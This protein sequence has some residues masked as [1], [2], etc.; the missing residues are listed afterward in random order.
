M[1]HFFGVDNLGSSM[2]KDRKLYY[3]LHELKSDIVALYILKN[4]CVELFGKD[5]RRV[6]YLVYLSEML[7]YIRRGNFTLFADSGAAF[8]AYY[9]LKSK[10]VIN[11]DD[12]KGLI[13][14]DF[15]KFDNEIDILFKFLFEIFN[16][17][18]FDTA[19][20][21]SDKVNKSERLKEISMLEDASIP[22]FLNID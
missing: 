10:G 21:F 6:I 3:I 4:C 9:Y 16:E 22:Y 18:K 19:L 20:E 11:Y 8:L 1:G 13:I 2:K 14:V 12:N 15:E 5:I 17:C 7:R